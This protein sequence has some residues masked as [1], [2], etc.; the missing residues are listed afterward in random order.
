M[1]TRTNNQG[2]TFRVHDVERASEALP[3]WRTLSGISA[4]VQSEFSRGEKEEILSCSGFNSWTVGG[5]TIH[6]LINAVHL[7]FSQHR[8]L[9]LSPDMIWVTICQGLAQHINNNSE[10]LRDRLVKHSGKLTIV[11]QRDDIFLQSPETAWDEV[12]HDLSHK[13]RS[14]VGGMYDRLVSNFSTTGDI[15]KTVC[16]IALL[17]AFQSYFEYA[18]YCMCGIPEITLEGEVSDWRNL[19]EKIEVLDELDLEWWTPHL[20]DITDHFERA[21]RG[22]VDVQHWQ[23]MYKLTEAYGYDRLN[24]WILKLI[25]Y[26][27][28]GHSG[29]FTCRNP[30]ISGEYADAYVTSRDLPTGLSQVPFTLH[31]DDRKLAMYFLGGFVGVEQDDE[32]LALRPKLGWAVRRAQGIDQVVLDL[33]SK[34]VAA[35]PLDASEFESFA[36]ALCES[37][38]WSTIPGDFFWLYKKCNGLA[39]AAPDVPA[40]RSFEHCRMI[41][42]PLGESLDDDAILVNLQPYLVFADMLDGTQIAINTYEQNIVRIRDPRNPDTHEVIASSFIEF[43][44]QTIESLP[45]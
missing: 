20:R 36:G 34:G 11:V 29:N 7:A 40:L 26:V 6:P 28:S 1:Q 35:P 30:L 19:R 25:P 42:Q 16:E 38:H 17:D 24:G 12:V 8:P 41:Q 4:L 27:Q 18:I 2:I 31:C 5:V 39:F 22:E 14:H 21:A 9:V 33:T 23:N 3:K 44:Q 10:R 13:L 43:L 45:N 32:T 37:S 15:E